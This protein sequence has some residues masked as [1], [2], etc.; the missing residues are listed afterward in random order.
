MKRCKVYETRRRA[1]GLT[2]AE[3]GKLAGVSG[4]AVSNFELGAEVSTPVYK[5]IIWAID[6]EMRKLDRQEYIEVKLKS[7]VY[8]LEHEND[9]EKMM[10]LVYIGLNANKLQLELAKGSEEDY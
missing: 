6:S 1:L 7:L 9:A 2:Q 8:Q 4:S 5:S 10:T 3:V